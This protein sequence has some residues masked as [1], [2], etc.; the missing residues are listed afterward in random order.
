MTEWKKENQSHKPPQW[1]QVSI[2]KYIQRKDIKKIVAKSE[3]GA[4]YITYECSSRF[5]TG[6]E[7]QEQK[8]L[9]DMQDKI[10]EQGMSIIEMQSN[11]E[12]LVCIKDL[13]EKI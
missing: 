11:I 6:Q 5:L 3:D 12:F 13:E 1:Q 4:E 9:S 7:Y 8:I 10:D 2:D